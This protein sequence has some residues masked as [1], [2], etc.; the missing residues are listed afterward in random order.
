MNFARAVSGNY[1]TP[2]ARLGRV[3]RR[4]VPRL[5]NQDQR[6]RP[7]SAVSTRID[8]AS[9]KLRSGR[10][11][12]LPEP[13]YLDA[14][15]L[16]FSPYPGL[17]RRRRQFRK[18][19]N[20]PKWTMSGTLDYDTPLGTGRLNANTTLSYRSKSQQF[21][22][23]SPGLDQKGFALWDASIVWRSAGNRYTIGLHGK[24]LTDKRYVTAG[25]NFLAQNPFT[26]AY[27]LTPAGNPIHARPKRVT[28]YYGNPRPGVR[29]LGFNF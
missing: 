12:D 9:P 20:T 16:E 17:G 24:N 10:H 7:A 27:I 6:G 3:M 8:C 25:Y 5:R 23:A 29:S 19:Q 2:G 18:V 28:A 1:K 26:G 14:K 21:E 22:L 13:R 11:A 4:L 15:Y